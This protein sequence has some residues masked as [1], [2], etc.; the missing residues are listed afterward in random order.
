MRV[1][2]TGVRSRTHLIHIAA[3]LRHQLTAGESLQVSYVGGASG[4]IGRASVTES[5]VRAFLPQDGALELEITGSEAYDAPGDLTYVSVGAPGIKPWVSMRR[6]GIRRSIT[7]V[8]TD[9]GIG[10]YGDWRTRRDAWRRQGVPEP[11]R[12]V[13]AVA[14]ETAAHTLTTTR[15]AMY[16]ET[17][18]WSLQPDIAAEFR[19][20]SDG[21]TPDPEDDRVVYLSSPWIELGVLSQDAYLQHLRDVAGDVAAVGKRLV[22]RPHPGEDPARYAEWEVIDG[23]LAAELDPRVISASG[24]VGGTSTA[25]LNLAA[26]YKMAAQRVVIPGLEHLETGLGSRQRALFDRFVPAVV[27]AGG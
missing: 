6:N 11:W 18:A 10:T 24:A 19:R 5:D 27:G 25:L 4:S 7:T 8:V 22:V 16:D 3:Y 20:H 9:E 12:S 23:P 1:V 17:D 21:A 15:W 14:V 2:I 13:R 26:L